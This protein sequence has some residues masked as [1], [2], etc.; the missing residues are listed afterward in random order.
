VETLNAE[1]KGVCESDLIY[2]FWK[3]YAI[4]DEIF[5]AGEVM[6]SNKKFIAEN[7]TSLQVNAS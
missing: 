6:E 1:F 2:H 5:S 3:V 4:T 7:V